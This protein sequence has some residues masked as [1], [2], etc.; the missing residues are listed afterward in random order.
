MLQRGDGYLLQTASVVAMATHPD[1]AAYAVTKHAALAFSEWL[2]LTYRPRGIKVSCFC[3]GP[4]LT[5]MLLS[6]GIPADHPVVQ[7]AA[8]PEEVA[9]RLVRAIEAE[10]FL[11]V[12]STMGPDSLTAKGADYERWI[13]DMTAVINS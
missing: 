9:E 8:T 1:K 7:N 5:P 12:D 4:M 3:P 10:Q 2:A 6:D 13:S 11:I